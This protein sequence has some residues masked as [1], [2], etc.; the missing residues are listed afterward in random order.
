MTFGVSISLGVF[1]SIRTDYEPTQTQQEQESNRK[2]HLQTKNYGGVVTASQELETHDYH[3]C[4]CSTKS[5]DLK[6][7]LGR[8]THQRDHR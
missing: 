3:P 2:T 6:I 5:R 7:G 1:L 4:P 8:I